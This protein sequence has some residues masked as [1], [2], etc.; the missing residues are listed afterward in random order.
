MILPP[1]TIC[2]Q[3]TP[4]CASLFIIARVSGGPEKL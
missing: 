3:A 2:V 1:N 4:D